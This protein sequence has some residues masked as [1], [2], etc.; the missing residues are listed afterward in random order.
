MK[1]KSYELL[2]RNK[3]L[4]TH[5]ESF[6]DIINALEAAVD[7]LKEMK[8]TNLIE[9][10]EGADDDYARFIT[11]DKATAEKYGFEEMEDYDEEDDDFDGEDDADEIDEDMEDEKEDEIIKD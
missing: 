1:E 11:T 8:A 4:S 3:Y 9:Y 5:A 7:Q 6:E 2:W 10:T